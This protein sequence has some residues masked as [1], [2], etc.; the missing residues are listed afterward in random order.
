MPTAVSIGQ[1]CRT[2]PIEILGVYGQGHAYLLRQFATESGAFR[3]VD[4]DAVLKNK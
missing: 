3:L 2:S 4:V 1:R